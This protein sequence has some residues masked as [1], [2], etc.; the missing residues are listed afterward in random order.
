MEFVLHWLLLWI[1]WF[2]MAFP[3]SHKIRKHTISVGWIPK[4]ALCKIGR[5]VDVFA[6]RIDF[7][8]F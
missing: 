7:D 5:Y 6:R 2:Q 3:E 1:S 4:N 8:G